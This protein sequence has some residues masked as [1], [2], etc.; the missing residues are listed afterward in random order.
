MF[1]Q[2]PYVTQD[3]T[4]E[5]LLNAALSQ[6]ADRGFH[7]ASIAKIAGEL[8]LTKQALLY[9]FRRKEDLYNEVL[10]RISQ[11]LLSAMRTYCDP[12]S[13]AA[14]QFEDMILG[15]HAAAQEHPMV[16]KV[17]MRELMDNQ[18]RDISPENSH[19]KT[20]LDEIVGA[21][22]RVDGLAALSFSRKFASVY[23]MLSAVEYF[24]ISGPTLSRMYG[25][26]E[27]QR[28]AASYPDELRAQA[29]RLIAAGSL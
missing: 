10:K 13:D 2:N 12:A 1:M 14:Q 20:V 28:I 23:Q 27:Y 9:Y 11:G 3:D 16:S 5:N 22:D 6:F 18:R 29:R 17:L 7:G 19:L 4:R 8:G 25:E 21:L 15:I 26:E 24:S